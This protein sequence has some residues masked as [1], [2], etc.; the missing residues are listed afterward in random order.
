MKR[1]VITGA[2]STGKSTLA[3]E[4]SDYYGEP[5][6]GEFVRSYVDAHRRELNQSDLE[7]IAEG[8]LALED[9]GLEQA[10]RLI[11]HDT[12]ILS[13]IIYAQVYFDT[14]IEWL[15]DRFL[16][17]DYSLYL[18]CMP[19]IPWEADAGQ[20]ESPEARDEL[21]QRFKHRLDILQLPYVEIHG[22]KQARMLQAVRAIDAI[23]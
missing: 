23:L 19:D 18:L 22:S 12:N 20:R 3:Q 6:T 14:A 5:C 10:Q 8:Q 9:A 11:F 1:I 4:L 13:S 15:N 2:E 16:E 17:R 21:H 7:P